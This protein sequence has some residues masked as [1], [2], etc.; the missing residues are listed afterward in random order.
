MQTLK[1]HAKFSYIDDFSRLKFVYVDDIYNTD[2]REKL[3]TLNRFEGAKPYNDSEFTVVL[4]KS[5]KKNG[6]PQDILSLAG[7]DVTVWVKPHVYNFVSKMQ[8]NKGVGV[9]GL[10]LVL[11]DIKQFT[12]L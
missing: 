5:D 7:L 1:L 8:K 9:K 11:Q 4:E 12:N 2:S 3:Q 10:Q 6:I